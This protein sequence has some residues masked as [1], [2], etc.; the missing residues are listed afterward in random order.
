MKTLLGWWPA[1]DQVALAVVQQTQSQCY[2]SHTI[3]DGFVLS[4]VAP[5][6]FFCKVFS[7]AKTEIKENESMERSTTRQNIVY[8]A[9]VCRVPNK[10]QPKMPVGE[11][12]GMVL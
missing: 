4:H 2:S 8:Q 3:P 6:F 10:D 9:T 1:A 11:A 7:W 12:H 5:V